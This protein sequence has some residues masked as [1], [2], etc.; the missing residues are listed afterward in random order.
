MS[1]IF[2]SMLELGLLTEHVKYIK[3]M[4]K[5]RM[6]LALRVL[7]DQLPEGSTFT[8]PRGGY[9][10]WVTLPEGIHCSK[11]RD[12]AQE[13]YRVS[14]ARGD[15]FCSDQSAAPGDRF[16]NCMRLCISHYSADRLLGGISALCAAIKECIDGPNGSAVVS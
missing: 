12:R 1:G 14:F 10:I 9:F 6:A 16:E 7:K 3:L 4:Y 8:E 15:R 13:K 11:F 5:V 2:S